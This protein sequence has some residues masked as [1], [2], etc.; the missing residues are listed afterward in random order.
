MSI[1]SRNPSY[2]RVAVIWIDWYPYHVARFRGLLAAL[3]NEVVG[4]ELIGGI[5]VHAGLKF[6]ESLPDDLPIQTLMPGKSWQEAGSF[7]LA[8]TLWKKLSAIRPE[9]VLVPGYYTLPGI[10]AALWARTHGAQSVLMSESTQ[11]DHQRIGL[12]ERLKSLGIRTLFSWAVIGGTAHAEYLRQLNFPTERI[13]RFYDVVDNAFFEEGAS[14]FRAQAS[15]SEAPSFLY[16]GRLA[17]EKNVGTLITSWISYREA[18]GTWPLVLVGDGPEAAVLRSQ[19]E[20]CPYAGS[21]YFPGLKSSH[22]LLP[23][24]AAAGCFV[25]PSTREPWGLVVNEAMASSLPVLV[26]S[27][28]GC[29]QDLVTPSRNG[30]LFDPDDSVALANRL[31]HMAS[32]PIEERLEMGRASA[33]ILRPYSPGNFGASIRSIA[34]AKGPKSMTALAG[35]P[36]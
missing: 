5:G 32:L 20:A 33:A 35:G 14:A 11:G 9:V 28:C 8:R 13:T 6:R 12:K 3:P 34:L 17:K 30:F 36:Q 4:I 7:V 27:R 10:A 21:V 1:G 18:G 24:Y 26:S 15:R 2:C 25:L 16:V 29:A 22:D 23:F 19:A 31:T